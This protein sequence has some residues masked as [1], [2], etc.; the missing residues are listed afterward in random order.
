M[1]RSLAAPLLSLLVLGSTATTP[2]R[3]WA[4]KGHVAVAANAERHLSPKAKA[5]IRALLGDRSIA[6][7]RLANWADHIKR[8]AVY[9]RKYPNNFYWHF[10]DIPVGAKGFDRARDARGG[11]N[12][13]DAVER[14]RKVL[15]DRKADPT[16]RKEA[17]LFLVHLVADLHQPLHC[18]ERKGDQGGN[19]VKVTYPGATS[20]RLNLHLVW[21]LHLVDA[22][23]DGLEPEDFARRADATISPAQAAKWRAGKVLDWIEEGHRLAERRAYKT[24]NGSDLPATGVVALD[25]GY[26]KK[27]RPVVREQ[28]RKAGIRLAAILN[29]AFP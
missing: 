12:V 21:D 1:L 13:L 9:R 14:F 29:A 6:D 23:L 20:P 25:N 11:D 28:L 27:N 5:G 8:S 7:S 24:A 19:K 17:L 26:V 18:A 3:A 22:V 10:L 4:E 16:T 2:A 15:A